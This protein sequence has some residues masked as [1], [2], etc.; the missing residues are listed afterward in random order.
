MHGQWDQGVEG[1]GVR[2]AVASFDISLSGKAAHRGAGVRGQVPGSLASRALAVWAVGICGSSAP[3][4][5]CA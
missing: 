3:R 2:L 1:R 5:L 4:L